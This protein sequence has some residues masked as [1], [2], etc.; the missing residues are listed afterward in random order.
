[1]GRSSPNTSAIFLYCLKYDGRFIENE[2]LCFIFSFSLAN[3][4]EAFDGKKPSKLKDHLVNLLAL[5][6]AIAQAPGTGMTRILC[7][8]LRVLT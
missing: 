7:S 3:S 6:A 2:C 8:V 4:F 1:M 5:N